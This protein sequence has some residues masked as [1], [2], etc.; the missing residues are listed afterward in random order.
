M[1]RTLRGLM[2]L[3]PAHNRDGHPHRSEVAVFAPR[4]GPTPQGQ[5]PDIM[6]SRARAC[7]HHEGAARAPLTPL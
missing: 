1:K 2:L 7:S 6:R 3:V 4:P 5:P